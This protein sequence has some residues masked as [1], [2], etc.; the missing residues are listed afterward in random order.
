MENDFEKRLK[1]MSN[2]AAQV[3]PVYRAYFP[4]KSAV[5]G[6]EVNRLSGVYSKFVEYVKATQQTEQANSRLSEK[7]A[8]DQVRQSNIPDK[9]VIL[10][11]YDTA[12]SRLAEIFA[13]MDSVDWTVNAFS[14][15]KQTSAK[16]DMVSLPSKSSN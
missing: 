10:R 5:I 2:L 1:R 8:F 3:Q 9:G 13:V 14:E 12:A 15:K 4:G 16:D 7:S 6:T 11:D